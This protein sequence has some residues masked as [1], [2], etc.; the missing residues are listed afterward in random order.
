M[1]NKKI[2]LP[3]RTVSC[4]LLPDHD[5]EVSLDYKKLSVF[6]FSPNL[7]IDSKPLVYDMQASTPADN[8]SYSPYFSY[9]AIS[10]TTCDSHAKN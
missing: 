7:L 10:L 2:R 1:S 9:S 4:M 3:E 6:F 8:K 5:I